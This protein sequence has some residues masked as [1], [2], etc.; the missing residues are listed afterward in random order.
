MIIDHYERIN[1]QEFIDKFLS[2]SNL[3]NNF[4]EILEDC[5]IFNL[6]SGE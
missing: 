5:I 4:L 6:K 3:P 1:N 2:I